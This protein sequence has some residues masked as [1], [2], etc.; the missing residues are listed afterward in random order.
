MTPTKRIV[1]NI[2]ATYGRS[3]YALICGLFTCRWV[4]QALGQEDYGL[5]GV[6][7]GMVV[8]IG[9]IN[10]VLGASVAR[11]YAVSVGAAN[12]AKDR[13]DAV[14]LCRQWFTSALIVHMVV[15]VILL[16]IGWPLGEWAILHGWIVVPPDRLSACQWTF[17]FACTAC[18]ISMV[19]VPFSAMYTA[20]QY[21]AEL[22]IYS[23][24]VTTFNV[25]FFYYMVAHSG[26]W[27]ARYAAWM[28]VM[29]IVPAIIISSRAAIVFPECRLARHDR[30]KLTRIKELSLFAAWNAIGSLGAVLRMQGIAILVNRHPEFGPMRNSSISVSH[31]L[32]GQA[33][34]LA[35][36]ML[37]AFQPA[38]ANAWGAKQYEASLSLASQACKIGTL[39]SMIFM[40]PLALELEEVLRLWLKEPPIYAAGICWSVLAA[41]LI[42][43]TSMGHM[44]VINASGKIA[45]YQATLGGILISTLLIAW[46][47]LWMKLGIYS[48]GWAI[49]MTMVLCAI[50]RVVFARSL[51]GMSSRCWLRGTMCPL[52]VVLVV[53]FA[54]GALPRCMLLPSI[55]RVIVTT[56]VV[57]CVMLPLSWFILLQKADRVYVTTRVATIKKMLFR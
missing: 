26:D 35:G 12:A 37:G 39:L 15:P 49:V 41:H 20:K 18:F 46:V 47:F 5:Y 24:C 30:W 4:L 53:S 57:E 23:F 40:V 34:T 36:S 55:W 19:S 7:G 52:L 22:T 17:R 51:V 11:F 9:F 10:S 44:L 25:V 43:R 27:L 29:V 42:D 3:L 48:V 54:V 2:I 14:E 32:A 8:F 16:G 45:C 28:A 21:I 50:G 1:L 38:I 6:I 56:V 31:Q 33:D 13:T